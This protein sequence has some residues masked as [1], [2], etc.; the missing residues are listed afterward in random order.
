MQLLVRPLIRRTP[1]E[2]FESPS[3]AHA[4]VVVVVAGAF[5]SALITQAIGIHPIFGAFLAGVAISSHAPLRAFLR[6]RIETLGS[7]VFVPLFFAFAGLRTEFSLLTTPAHWLTGAGILAVAI[8]AKLGGCATAAR[9]TGLS[10]RD[11]LALGALM[12]TRGLM[13]LIVLNVGYE[14]GVLPPPVFAMFVLMALL[15][16]AM[17]T[18]IVTALVGSPF[19]P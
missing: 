8:L 17:T 1:P 19:W 12:N 4:A 13:E 16:T 10:G 5:A 11:A 3:R 2:A 15:T 7:A 18:P 6:D 9:W 14:L